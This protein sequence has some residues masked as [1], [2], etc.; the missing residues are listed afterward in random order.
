MGDQGDARSQKSG[1][2]LMFGRK[3]A[4][5]PVG[6]QPSDGNAD[7]G[8]E[9]VPDQVKGGDLISKKLD[10]E[11]RETGKNDWPSGEK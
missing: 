3:L 4:G 2:Q 1:Q 7:E 11:E 8:V 5:R 10:S 9:S 6:E